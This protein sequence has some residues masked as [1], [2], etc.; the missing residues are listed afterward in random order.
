MSN[1]T[2]RNFLA[3]SAVTA[4]LAGLAGCESSSTTD[5]EEE[6]AATTSASGS[7]EAPSAD[8][9]P[10]EPD[11]EGV[12]ALWTSEEVRDG[13]TR[14]TN[15]EGGAEI[16]VMDTARIIQVD[17]LAFRDMN[18]D[19]QLELWEDWR[20]SAA[21]R[22]AALAETLSA[23]EII[24]LM[25]AGGNTSGSATSV[26]TDSN[27]WV[28]EGSR[29]GVSRLSSNADS[30]ASDISWINGVQELCEQSELG[31]P[32]L[33][34]SDPYVLFDVPSSSGLAACMD[35]DIWR[36]AGM[37]QARAWRATGV[38]CELG[39][40]IDVYS[41]PIGTRLSGAVSEDPAVARDF[42]AAFGGGMQSTW[43][44]DEA[45]EDLGWGS[46]SCAVMLKH[47]VG[48]GSNEG[49][50]DDHSD[51]G[52][53][54][55][56]PG[57]NF[58][59]H[60]VPFLDGGMNLD[61]E[62]GEMAAIMP[63]YGIAY[64][65]NDP[66]ALGEHVG[67]AY[68]THNISI[69]RNAGWDGLIC[70]D[71]MILEHIPHGVLDLTVEE[72]FA[73]LM[74][75]TVSQHG[76]TFDV[77]IAESA[78]EL[79]VEEQGEDEALSVLQENARRVFEL[80]VKVDLF[81][82]PYSDRTIAAEVFSNEAPSEF[83]M[84]AATKCVIMLKN[85]DG[86]IAE[87]A[88][89]DKPTV[90]IPLKISN[91][92]ASLSFAPDIAEDN[93]TVIT[94][95]LGE[96]TGEAGS[97]GSASYQESDIVRLTAEEL[98]DVQYAIVGVDNPNDAYQGVEGGP[99]F[100]SVIM[101]T[102][103]GDSEAVWK[104]ISLQYRPFTADGDYVR[105]ESLNPEDEFGE[106]ENR[107]VYGESTYATNESDL[108][109]VIDTKSNLPDG[110]KL[111]LVV[112]M[113]RPMCF[114]EI[115]PYAD[116]IL[117]GFSSIADQAFVNI[118][119]GSAEPYG[120]LPYQMPLDMQTVFEQYEDV[121][122]DMECYVDSEGNTYDFCFGLDWSGVIDDERTATY[123]ASPVTDPDIAVVADE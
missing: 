123:K 109:L 41:N 49:G 106:Y 63:C 96:P 43:G 64:D 50:R 119:T 116:V 88:L 18:G 4:G 19:G 66:D 62:T 87:G 11:A 48:E 97:D 65:P 42:A 102:E 15:P 34:Y 36:K 113:D 89:S 60:L 52:K 47:Y 76:G 3:A 45:T 83:G 39:P 93:F 90:Y 94:D 108:D 29:A 2:R 118:I 110:A 103:D 56:F 67:S 114:Y 54:N 40:Q 57:S 22:A 27:D 7:M 26:S 31:I 8:S 21:D 69:L 81:D 107:S 33:N 9:Y 59:A 71:W 74:N 80:M 32:Y 6:V 5:G 99:T 38:R 1:V 44:D 86:T 12:E 100:M 61:S 73:K 98:A 121:P 55:V 101:G 115:E 112:D 37:W 75:N 117:A 120:L 79:M 85:A 24:P 51:S 10:I 17:G 13:W 92:Q 20:Q 95:T 14:V 23:E 91:G 111:I 30:Y 25:F 16:G 70:T 77:D 82:Q 68:S 84:D 78:Y 53:W 58:N 122:R 28:E 72:R 46:E 35:K 104:P 105:T